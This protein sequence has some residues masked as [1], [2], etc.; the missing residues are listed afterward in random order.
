LKSFHALRRACTDPGGR[1]AV[2]DGI[3]R[4]VQHSPFFTVALTEEIGE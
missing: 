1:C 4:S 2:V 3:R